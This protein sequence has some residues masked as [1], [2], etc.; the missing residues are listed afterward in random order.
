MSLMDESP[1]NVDSDQLNE[2]GIEIKK[3]SIRINE[4]VIEINDVSPIVLSGAND[5][6]I[7]LIEKILTH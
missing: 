1:S 7:E 6:N 5:E 3:N 2:L 4:K